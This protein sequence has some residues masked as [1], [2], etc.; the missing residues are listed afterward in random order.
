[1]FRVA[2][3]IHVLCF[4]SCAISHSHACSG[5][6]RSTPS[7]CHLVWGGPHT[8]SGGVSHHATCDVTRGADCHEF[9]CVLAPESA[10]PALTAQSL[11]GRLLLLTSVASTEGFTIPSPIALPLESKLPGVLSRG[12][13]IL[14]QLRHLRI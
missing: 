8:H 3:L 14:L 12:S 5:P 1:M 10:Q 9:C 2:L 13:E 7:H 6:Q 4:Q 11:G